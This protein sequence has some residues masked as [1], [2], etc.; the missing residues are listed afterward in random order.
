MKIYEYL[1]GFSGTCGYKNIAVNRNAYSKEKEMVPKRALMDI[2]DHSDKEYYSTFTYIP[3]TECYG[4]GLS[5][6]RE[7][8]E[9][10]VSRSLVIFNHSGRE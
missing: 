1:S 8:E 10:P 9:L 2:C 5:Y 4:F 7:N 6:V 3:G